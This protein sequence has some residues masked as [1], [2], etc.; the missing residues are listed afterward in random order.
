MVMK[1]TGTCCI[2][3]EEQDHRSIQLAPKGNTP[4]FFGAFCLV[5]LGF[6]VFR[7]FGFFL[8]SE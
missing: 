3:T 5:V 6:F 8:N 7:L 4:V 1:A 2:V